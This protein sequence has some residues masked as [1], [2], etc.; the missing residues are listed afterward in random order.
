MNLPLL[1]E[2]A[3]KEYTFH[4]NECLKNSA[5]IQAILQQF[6]QE[7]ISA[8]TLS[9][10]SRQTRMPAIAPTLPRALIVLSQTHHVLP[11]TIIL[12]TRIYMATSQISA[13]LCDR[14]CQ[15][16]DRGLTPSQIW[17]IVLDTLIFIFSHH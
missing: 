2:V 11:A 5:L 15:L 3:I 1:D 8:L 10:S 17:P 16:Y 6:Q 7:P 14:I 13:E 9:Q 12:S 4:D